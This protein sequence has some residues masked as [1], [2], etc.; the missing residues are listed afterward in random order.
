M[1]EVTEDKL[2]ELP[3]VDVNQNNNHSNHGSASMTT[4]EQEVKENG[5]LSP[6]N[7]LK[8]GADCGENGQ[9]GAASGAVPAV[10]VA[11]TYISPQPQQQVAPSVN[12][13]NNTSSASSSLS[14]GSY[15]NHNHHGNCS[16][17]TQSSPRGTSPQGQHS[18]PNHQHV[19]HV[20][21]Q[22]G[23][24]FSVRV[25]DQIQHIQGK[26]IFFLHF[27]LPVLYEMLKNMNRDRGKFCIVLI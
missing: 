21:V 16:P 18:P 4:C 3:E 1:E 19:V 24:T 9:N 27:V 2:S 15:S 11:P 7:S 14:N 5:D 25:G 17:I 8:S 23:E 26:D 6:T 22:P 12:G 10:T 20:H 13:I